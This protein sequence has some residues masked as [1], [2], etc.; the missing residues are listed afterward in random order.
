MKVLLVRSPSHHCIETEVPEAVRK[1]NVSYPPL[2][3]LAIA[4]YLKEHST[5]EVSI[6][7]GLLHQYSYTEMEERIAAHAPDVVGITAFTVGLIDARKTVQAARSA[8]VKHV[9][10]G[11]PHVNDFPRES[12]FFPDIDAAVCGEGQA[13]LPPILEAL[14][15][16]KPLDDLPGVITM[17]KAQETASACIERPMLSDDLDTYPLLDLKLIEYQRYYDVLGKGELFTTIITSRGCPYRCTFCNT[18]RDRYRTMS[19]GRI[20]EEIEEKLR[21]GVREIYFVD[22]TF[23][24]TNG[25]VRE[26][27]EEILRRG[28]KFRWTARFRVKGVDRALLTLMKRAGCNRLQ[29]GVEQATDEALRLLQKGVSIAEIEN[30][31]RLCREV[32]IRTVAYFMLGTQV[33]KTREDLLRTID[34]SIRLQPDFVMYNI[35]TPFPGTTL[36]DEGLAQGVLKLEPWLDFIRNPSEDFVP[37]TWDQYFKPDELGEYLHLAYRKFYFRPRFILQN[38][39]ELNN[40]RDFMRKAK[41]GLTLLKPRELQARP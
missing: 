9:L 1:E 34:F 11:G 5:H 13:T 23:N 37:Q 35:M 4:T 16:G 7:D 24:I 17:K 39:R 21:L 12:G 27:C 31:F 15:E 41:A 29:F 2:S 18:P 36:F 30:A 38:L 22:D 28:L 32:G 26:M 8:G 10:L 3:L 25:R 40:I 20:C 19:A 6:L 14:E 33:E